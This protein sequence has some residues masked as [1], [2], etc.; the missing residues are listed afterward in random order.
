M[1]TNT[2]MMRVAIPMVISLAQRSEGFRF[3]GAGSVSNPLSRGGKKLAR[4][5]GFEP[6]AA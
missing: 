5:E 3:V 2:Q 4:P 1:N 6:P